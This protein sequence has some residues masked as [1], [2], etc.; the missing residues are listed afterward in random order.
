MMVNGISKEHLTRMEKNIRTFIWLGRKGNIAW[1][2]AIRPKTR[3]GIGA[4]SP[5]VLYK[6]TKVVWLR[7]WLTPD[8]NRPKWTWVAN[9][10]IEET[11]Q[12]SP[13]VDE[14]A[15]TEWI[16]QRWHER[17]RSELLTPS[18]KEM[19]TAAQK[20]NIKISILRAPPE[21]KLKMPAFFH[22]G[23]KSSRLNSSKFA[24]CLRR[25]HDVVTIERLIQVSQTNQNEPNCIHANGKCKTFAIK[26]LNNLTEI[27]RPN[28]NSPATNDLYHTPR[29]KAR[30]S[31]ADIKETVI[32]FNPDPMDGTNPRHNVRIFGKR[33]GYINRHN[34]LKTPGNPLR[35]R[36]NATTPRRDHKIEIHTDGSAELNGWE[37][38][39]A[40][41]G[42]W[43][44]EDSDQNLG[45]KLDGIVQTNQRAELTAILAALRSNSS[46]D[47]LL[48]YSDSLTSLNIL[49]NKIEHYEDMGWHNVK[50]ANI[51][52][53]I[54]DEL[55]TRQGTCEFMWVEA[56]TNNE[57]NNRAEELANLGR[58]GDDTF[59]TTETNSTNSRAIHDGA[60]LSALT[61]KDI[62][63]ILTE[64]LTKGKGE[65]PH[66]E[67]LDEAK[68]ELARE[69][70]LQPTT[71]KIIEGI[72][73]LRTYPRTRDH[74]WN[75]ALGRI[76]LGTYWSHIP[77]YEHRAFCTACKEHGAEEVLENELHLWLGCQFN[78][79]RE[80]WERAKEIWH[81]TSLQ[82][83][84][85]I[86][87]GL[88][89]GLGAISLPNN[90]GKPLISHDTAKLQ[91]IIAATVWAIW[92]S[93][94]M[95]TISEMH[96]PPEEASRILTEML[97]DLIKKMVITTDYKH[98]KANKRQSR[99]NALWTDLAEAIQ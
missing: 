93:R 67:R 25:N 43:Y 44:G 83:W 50:N 94:N 36:H 38:S 88:I 46:D 19:L 51:L 31:A 1:E 87:L 86:T 10:I 32:T 7:K 52:M 45:L 30:N 9:A 63:S 72:W 55:R 26:L 21:L 35:I 70:G 85:D 89:R 81:R 74:I 18:L 82:N 27:W 48:I 33:I 16:E 64:R 84:P 91:I 77:D 76:K 69:T 71:E 20:H 53:D 96:T 4:P 11:K 58:L 56:H 3:G 95:R 37:N 92:K 54:V 14:D 34:E 65:I 80:A 22:P 39:T 28:T 13:Q 5:R 15:I 6:A 62:Y 57:G 78:G 47:D 79:Q 49:C 75:M 29:R 61:M 40:G 24:K 42:N 59:I 8:E 12:T 73:K 23:M 66:P 90:E 68:V 98:S 41:I 2:R 99:K 60:R 97:Q 17:I